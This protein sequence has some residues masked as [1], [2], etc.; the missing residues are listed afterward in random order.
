MDAES[1]GRLREVVLQVSACAA[2]V[3]AVIGFTVLGAGVVAGKGLVG[4]VSALLPL[5]SETPGP[6]DG[7]G[8]V[9]ERAKAAQ[10]A[11]RA[12]GLLSR[13]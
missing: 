8:K 1:P 6:R 10:Q 11:A 4:L 12:S 2:R 9:R 5:P 7:T 13:S 3:P